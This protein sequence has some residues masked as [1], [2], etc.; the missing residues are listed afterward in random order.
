MGKWENGCMCE[1]VGGYQVKP[2]SALK[3][4]LTQSQQ[5]DQTKLEKNQ[6]GG[7][8]SVS[9]ERVK[10]VIEQFSIFVSVCLYL[11]CTRYDR[12][13][14]PTCELVGLEIEH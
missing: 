12:Y 1:W 13:H 3:H 5:I 4:L 8:K 10:L 7:G 11:K 9:E 2:M 14:A 6:D